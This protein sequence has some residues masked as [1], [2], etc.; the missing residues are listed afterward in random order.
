MQI[1]SEGLN[2]KGN[3]FLTDILSHVESHFAAMLEGREESLKPV[4]V[5]DMRSR[6]TMTTSKGW[7][8]GVADTIAKNI[9]M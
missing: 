4:V 3:E 5:E 8:F 7:G 1:G 9:R 2:G 6:E